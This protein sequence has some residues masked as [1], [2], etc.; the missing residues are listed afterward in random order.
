M[1]YSIDN[2]EFTEFQ[3]QQIIADGDRMPTFNP[4]N[5]AFSIFYHFMHITLSPFIAVPLIFLIEGCNCNV[6]FNFSFL[7]WQKFDLTCLLSSIIATMLCISGWM[8]A[9]GFY[10]DQIEWIDHLDFFWAFVGRQ[11]VICTKYS[12]FKENHL[13]I[14]RGVKMSFELKTLQ[15]VLPVQFSSLD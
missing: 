6:N 3:L 4:F 8:L 1:T 15:L 7:M 14:L 9:Y 13:K 11:V 5:F 2:E 12:L 10:T